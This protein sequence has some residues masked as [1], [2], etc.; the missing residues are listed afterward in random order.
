MNG[1]HTVFGEH[2]EFHGDQK[3][4]VANLILQNTVKKRCIVEHRSMKDIFDE[5]S[6][7]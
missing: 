1:E 5:E 6:I 7:K 2:A 4:F 3:T